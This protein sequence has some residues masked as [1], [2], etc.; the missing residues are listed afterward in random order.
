M[1]FWKF[2]LCVCVGIGVDTNRKNYT[3]PIADFAVLI[4]MKSEADYVLLVA[5]FHTTNP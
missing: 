2:P 4:V 1:L 5:I 3:T